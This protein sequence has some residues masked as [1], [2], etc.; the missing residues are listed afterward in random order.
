MTQTATQT[1]A[2]ADVDFPAERIAIDL[3]ESGVAHVRLNRA[4]KMNALDPEMFEAIIAA[5]QRLEEMKGMRVVV[6]S[7]E[8]RAFCAGLDTSSFTRTPSSDAAPLTERTH[9]NVNT[10]QQVAMQ[11]RKLAV[12]VIA[13][14]HGV[15]FGGGLQIASGADIRIAHPETR[16]SIMELKWGLVPDMGG[17]AL[18]RGLVR[19]DVLRELIYTNRE[20][21]GAE[22]Q[23][24][25]LATETS[26]EP[27]ARALEL[28]ET[29]ANRNPQA[30]RAAKRLQ[31][32]MV[33]GDTDA[34][35][36]AESV[37]QDAIMR[38]P[39]QVEAVM[40]AMQKRKPNFE[41]V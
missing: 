21:T 9:G 13:A 22:A 11:W 17:Y 30:I 41:D 2:P 31:E 23:M 4:D 8:G 37:E 40:A 7:G 6:L 1:T 29:I 3:S 10:F 26:E 14:V 34:I 33:E 36:L 12:P 39:N 32:T 28:A 27:L 24:L 20:F 16:M 19:D 5:G 15:C 35:L 25:G 38:T 18:W